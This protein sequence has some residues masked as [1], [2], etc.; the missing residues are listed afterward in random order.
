MKFS[1]SRLIFVC[2]PLVCA[3]ACSKVAAAGP[4]SMVVHGKTV[5]FTNAYAHH[6][7]ASYD[8][9]VIQSTIALSDKAID[10]KKIK[11]E[12]GDFL[13]NLDNWLED[14][15][16]AYWQATF[17]PDGEYW[18]GSLRLPGEL[19]LINAIHCNLEM[20]RNDAQRIEGSCRTKD[21]KEKDDKKEG[22][23]VDVKFAIGF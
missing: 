15:K 8:K 18:T 20:T 13:R 3:I 19:Q 9:D 23:Y 12:G 17:Y 16:A 5:T 2:A 14:N 22:V 21:E 7:P 4:G 11:A 1:Y 10:M 6:H